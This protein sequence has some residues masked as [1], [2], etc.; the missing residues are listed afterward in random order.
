MRR[1][2]HAWSGAPEAR[3][4][5]TDARSCNRSERRQR[6]VF[7]GSKNT[8]RGPLE[9]PR[10]ETPE[11]ERRTG[12]RRRGA[13]ARLLFVLPIQPPG[14]WLL[15]RV[16]KKREECRGLITGDTRPEIGRRSA[17]Q[18]GVC[19][20]LGRRREGKRDGKQGRI[21]R[22][23][24]RM[25]QNRRRAARERLVRTHRDCRGCTCTT[26]AAETRCRS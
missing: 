4:T 16:L 22:R 9:V 6:R 24:R 8:R 14:S 7:H 12:R 1:R 17:T 5:W 3:V 11:A 26:W 25:R 23:R 20:T 13:I 10:P 15:C 19:T 2:E 21:G 18:R